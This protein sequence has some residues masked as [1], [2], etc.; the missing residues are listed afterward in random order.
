MGD[1]PKFYL[2]TVEETIQTRT[3]HSKLRNR[4]L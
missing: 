2:G 4:A 1:A 3:E